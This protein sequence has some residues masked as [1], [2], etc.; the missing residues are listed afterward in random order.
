MFVAACS[1]QLNFH[2]VQGIKRNLSIGIKKNNVLQL[3]YMYLYVW[4]DYQKSFACVFY[5][6]V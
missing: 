5:Y 2:Q 4:F 6:H 1:N 3:K